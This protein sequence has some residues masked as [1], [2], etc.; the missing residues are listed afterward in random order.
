MMTAVSV[1]RM[2]IGSDVSIEIRDC[3]KVN[4]EQQLL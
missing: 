1:I 3:L 2:R 4:N